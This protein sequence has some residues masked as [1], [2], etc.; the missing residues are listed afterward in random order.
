MGSPLLLLP[1]RHCRHRRK[2]VE[3]GEA[4]ADGRKEAE[5]GEAAADGRKMAAPCRPSS[6]LPRQRLGVPSSSS[7]RVTI[8]A[9]KQ[10]AAVAAAGFPSTEHGTER[11]GRGRERVE[12]DSWVPLS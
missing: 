3:V 9:N 8:T 12:S 6:L 5:V 11:G 2:E 7:L 10:K 1:A 4:A